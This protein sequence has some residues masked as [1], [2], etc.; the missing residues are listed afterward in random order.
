MRRDMHLFDDVIPSKGPCRRAEAKLT[1]ADACHVACRRLI[2]LTFADKS[3]CSLSY[4]YYSAP[5][6]LSRSFQFPMQ[7]LTR[8]LE[9]SI[10]Y[11]K[12]ILKQ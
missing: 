11:L 5:N 1:S 7:A 2:L 10:L 12:F 9:E 3:P 8:R 4:L 6:L